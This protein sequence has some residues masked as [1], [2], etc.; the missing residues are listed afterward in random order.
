MQVF[1]VVTI[2]YWLGLK[3]HE[4]LTGLDVLDQYTVFACNLDGWTSWSQPNLPVCL[5]LSKSLSHHLVYAHSQVRL[6]YSQ[7]VPGNQSYQFPPEHR[8][9]KANIARFLV[10][11]PQKLCRL[12]STELYQL[13]RTRLD[14]LWEITTQDPECRETWFVGSHLQKLTQVNKHGPQPLEAYSNEIYSEIRIVILTTN[15]GFAMLLWKNC[16]F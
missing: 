15:F 2:R 8:K 7:A 11:Q 3:S 16:C 6:P 13:H 1:H 5:S 4:G 14:S 10:T 9:T 12:N